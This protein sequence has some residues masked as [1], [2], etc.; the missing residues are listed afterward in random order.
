MLIDPAS[1]AW[2]EEG[3]GV[4]G[5]VRIDVAE[6]EAYDPF[7]DSYERGVDAAVASMFSTEEEWAR[8]EA[9]RYIHRVYL[10]RDAKRIRD[11]LG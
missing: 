3:Q 2:Q 10:A 9:V 4:I 6:S 11:A 5:D 1:W 7:L 8:T